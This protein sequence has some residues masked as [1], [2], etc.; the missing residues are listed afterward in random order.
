VFATEPVTGFIDRR[1]AGRR[2]AER[3]AAYRRERPIVLGLPRGGVVV[4]DEVARALEAPLDVLVARKVGAPQQPELAIGAVAPGG[5]R[6]FEPYY[7]R[8]LN[9]SQDDLDRLA[10]AE[11]R[12]MERR[13]VS[14]RGHDDVPA[15]QDRTVILVDDGVATGATALAAIEA[16]RKAS[17][18]RIVLAAAVCPPDVAEH[19]REK[20]DEVVCL[21]EPEP[22]IAVGAWFRHFEEVSDDEVRAILEGSRRRTE[23]TQRADG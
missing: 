20:A 6:F 9:L 23:L 4:A 5:V 19:L 22:F 10:E 11:T 7:V 12:E 8:V 13:I 14:F 1:D 15:V 18:G 2:L 3:L 17:A 16:L 21:A